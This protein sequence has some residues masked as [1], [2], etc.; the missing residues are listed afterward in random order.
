MRW[1]NG[2]VFAILLGSGLACGSAPPR[3]S[4]RAPNPNGCY[5]MIFEQPG[6][7]SAGD[8]LNGP[9]K[10]PSLETLRET[11]HSRWTNRIR[12]L[13]VGPAATVT[14]FTQPKFAGQSE[15]YPAGTAHPML[16]PPFSTTIQSLEIACN[17]SPIQQ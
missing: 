10:W 12:S 8:V 2:I 11:N 6:F 3:I 14:A 9:G 13:R 15:Q 7:E 4:M 5:V 16:T 17:A 1:C